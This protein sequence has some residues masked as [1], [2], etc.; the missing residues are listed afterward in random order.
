MLNI[1]D[2]ILEVQNKNMQGLL[3]N[4]FGMPNY[5]NEPYETTSPTHESTPYAAKFYQMVE[6]AQT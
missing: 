5:G 3:T 6:K 2:E 4:A 1:I